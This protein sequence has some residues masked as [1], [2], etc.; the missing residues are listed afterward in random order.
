MSAF[1]GRQAMA[2][3]L[4]LA[5]LLLGADS[6]WAAKYNYQD[7]D[8]LGGGLTG[9]YAINSSGQVAGRSQT[10]TGDYHPFLWTS[11]GGIQDLHGFSGGHWSSAYGINS[12]SQVVGS[13]YTGPSY[14]HAF[15]WTSSGGIQDLHTLAG[16]NWSE[17]YAINSGGQIVGRSDTL[18]PN[19]T[20]QYHAFLYTAAGGMQDLSSLGDSNNYS[21]AEAINDRGQVAGYY[22]STLV[23]AFLWTSGTMHDL[24]TLGGNNA[25]A[26]GIN[27]II[28][29]VGSSQNSSEANRAFLWTAAS[30]MQDLGTLGGNF[31]E[32][33]A[34]N[35]FG[36]VVGE[37]ATG[38]GEI[39]AFVWIAA[40]GIQ[41][42]NTLLVNPPS[43][44]FLKEALAINDA[45]QITGV[46]N[47]GK[48]FL[49]TLTQPRNHDISPIRQLLVD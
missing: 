32:A 4:A 10:A 1:R 30:G 19:A 46:T 25:Q 44:D 3:C 14:P 39:H 36:Q 15:S 16:G 21:W 6:L 31:A 17:A 28:Q 41:D 13:S 20:H 18:L 2:I 27:N 11:A 35:T 34:I 23:G 45:G 9:A 7:L 37:S 29:V 8:S 48:A 38:G 47:N 26:Y 40:P 22:G 24:G 12:S 42:L 5:V 33:W 49:L 43:G